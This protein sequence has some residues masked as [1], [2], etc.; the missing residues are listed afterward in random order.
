ML[1]IRL[2]ILLILLVCD[3][4]SNGE[5]ITSPA[6]NFVHVAPQATFPTLLA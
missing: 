3:K 1:V 6:L 2:I 5:V 4:A